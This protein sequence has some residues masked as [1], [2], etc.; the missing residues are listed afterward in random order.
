[1]DR[2]PYQCLE[3]YE[4]LL[5]QVQSSKYI[6]DDPRKLKPGEIDALPEVRPAKADPYDLADEDREMVAELRV[7]IANVKGKKAK[8][9]ARERVLAEAR[10]LA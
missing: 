10:R 6:E 7:R 8:R 5:E 4:E 3:H 1:M 2:T 9:K